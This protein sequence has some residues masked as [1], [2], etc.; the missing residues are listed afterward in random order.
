M[1]D[2]KKYTERLKKF[3]STVQDCNAPIP[4]YEK[5]IEA[6]IYAV[7]CEYLDDQQ[8]NKALEKFTE[9][10][11]DWNDL[12]VSRPEEVAEVLG[13]NKPEYKKIASNLTQMLNAVFEKYDCLDIEHLKDM[14]KREAREELEKIN[15][16]EPFCSNYFLMVCMDAHTVPLSDGMI[17]YLRTQKLIH[18][19]ADNADTQG[20]VER[21][22]SS[23]YTYSFFYELLNL[24]RNPEKE[25]SK[26]KKTKKKTKTKKTTKKKNSK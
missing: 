9:H 23:Q 20:F 1:K 26:N 19:D 18:P 13:S 24:S 6:M 15:E 25:P 5:S 3:I 17:Q 21:V 10:F 7:L 2:S 11:V 16:L 14:G 12:R 4:A 8:A 22:L